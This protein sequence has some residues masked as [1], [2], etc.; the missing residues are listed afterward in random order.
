MD[1][2][3]DRHTDSIITRR[4]ALRTGSVVGFAITTGATPATAQNIGGTTRWT[5]TTGAKVYS[6]PTIVDDF[7]YV[8]DDDGTVYA[9]NAGSGYKLWEFKTNKR[10]RS[11]PLVVD[12]TVYI[13]SSDNSL[14]AIDTKSGKE[15]WT[16]ETDGAIVSSPVVVNNTLYVG[17]RDSTIYAINA[18]T[19]QRLWTYET[20]GQIDSS[21]A[22]V[23]DIIIIGSYDGT[24]YALN[25]NS[26]KEVWTF[27]TDGEIQTSPTVA[28]KM[29]YV[30]SED[31]NVYAVS[32]NS[33]V[34]QW[35]QGLYRGGG[36]TSPT[37]AAGA[38]SRDTLFIVDRVRVH[39]L[40]AAVGGKRWSKRFNGSNAVAPTV[41]NDHVF[42]GD[43]STVALAAGEGTTYWSGNDKMT[44]AP[45]GAS[46]AIFF[47][48][49]NNICALESG[50]VG[51]SEDSR[52]MLG[53]LGHH[54]NWKHSD[55]SITISPSVQNKD[56]EPSEPRA[57]E[58]EEKNIDSNESESS[59]PETKNTGSDESKS[60]APEENNKSGTSGS[61]PGFG[62]GS[63][64]G[65]LGVTGYILKR[66][67]TNNNNN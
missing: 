57:A 62:T 23:N 13:G 16:F 14:Y 17:S 5:Y 32:V 10:V 47:G 24:V 4:D 20:D 50:T 28:N 7:L 36:L 44:S 3:R 60:P 38:Y 6:S 49:N 46:G 66:R 21:P 61:A 34:E 18:E 37:V 45:T 2:N 39:A 67:L 35:S 55:Q 1:F 58:P 56:T 25:T 52:V 53:S 48:S 8:G 11:S 9:L 64:I 43:D 30:G 26:G 54:G 33:G 51:D 59:A 29:V 15:L 27:E 65:A 40:N 22:V 12:G 41:I 31:S 42:I 19:G 63:A